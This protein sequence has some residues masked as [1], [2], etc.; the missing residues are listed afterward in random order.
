MATEPEPTAAP[1]TPVAADP[2]A[3]GEA[4]SR[5]IR[6]GGLRVAGALTGLFAGAISAPLVV[7]HLGAA[8]Y[9]HYLTVAS[10]IFI[11]TALSEGGLA[12]VAVRQFSIADDAERRHLI[13]S[14]TGLRLVLGLIGGLIA[15]GF[16]LLAG[17]AHVLIVGLGL[18]A[19]G[20]VLG[21][22]QGTYS[23]ALSGT[24]RLTALAWIDVFRSL[25]TTLLLVG[26]VI[27]GSGLSGFYLVAAIVQGAALL[28]TAAL[29]RRD[30]PLRPTVDRR[31]WSELLHE[32]A[33]YAMA[34]TLGVVYFQVALISMSLLDSGTQTGYYAI[35]FRIVEIVNGIPWLLAASVLPLLAVA[36]HSDRA[37]LRFV[38][39]RVFEGAVIAGGWVAIIIVI[40]ARFGIEVIAGTKADPSV[41]VLRIMG[42]G[43]TATF[44]VSSW[45][46]VLLA[47]RQYRQLVLANLG[48]L[49]LAIGL[50]LVVIPEL[51]ARGGALTTAVLELTLAASY[52]ALLARRGIVPSARF[53]WRFLVAL[54]LG[55]GAGALGLQ[56]HAVLG[57]AGGSAVYFAA[58][59][60]L[61]AIP[62]ELID[63]IPWRR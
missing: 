30:V 42:I 3:V 15:V 54:A 6:G 36:A 21:S 25:A 5:V 47:M 12:N 53:V 48:A 40:G 18:G 14:L 28:L 26:L 45:G 20:F 9:G 29:V 43:V 11:I 31:R 10:V 2:Y 49:A 57:V 56:V 34:A 24:L 17:Y 51:H 62:S 4:G 33:L 55:L 35:A 63:A 52:M 8:D 27:A 1:L 19:V 22:L 32:T 38:A 61:R 41:S 46:Y 16:G 7:R 44:V 59:W 13:S 60:L 39:G 23:V 37:R 50:S 58:L